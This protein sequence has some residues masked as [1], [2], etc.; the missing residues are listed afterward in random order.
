MKI[1]IEEVEFS[2]LSAVDDNGRVFF[3]D[4]RVFRAIRHDATERVL[5]LFSSGL[6]DEL[7]SN[8]LFP[9]SWVTDYTLEGY[10]LVV[11]HE[12][13]AP[14]VYP[15]EWSFSMLQDAALTVLKVNLISK[16]FGYQ[17]KDCHG[18][19]VIFDGV[20]PKFIDMGSFVKVPEDFQGWLAYEEF[21]RFFYYP[22]S[23][24]KDGNGYIAQKMLMGNMCMPHLSYLLYK[25]PLYRLLNPT[26]V[27]KF[28]ILFSALKSNLPDSMSLKSNSR[29]NYFAIR[30]AGTDIFPFKRMDFHAWT[31]K[32]EK[33]SLK[34]HA[35]MWGGYH[36]QYNKD[37]SV[38]STPRFDRVV[39]IVKE[40]K[41]TSILEL[42]GNQGVVAMLLTRE[43]PGV[44]VTCTDY[45]EY[46]VDAMYQ[47]A[48][49]R[50]ARLSS[51]L[52]DFVYPTLTSYGQNPP[53]R[54]RA[55]VVLALAVTHH[56]LLTGKMSIDS[57]FRILS[58]YT[59]RYL[60][61]E[62]MPL[63]L[64]GGTTAPP[65]PEWY[66]ADWFRENF[67]EHYELI[68]EEKLEINR[69]LFVGKRKDISAIDG[70]K[71]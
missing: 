60:L 15:Y 38:L 8:E 70:N 55:E 25:N 44:P 63:G 59:K 61:V 27:E 31:R 1:N 32:I 52:L 21:L 6:I 18:F 43:L 24:W 11:E 17:T 13:C 64:Y 30:L 48:K 58:T 40:L 7:S 42:A 4:G 65:V 53:D 19:N 62:F 29:I 10:G 20:H 45:D 49:K 57:V 16:R 12:R 54:F 35:T 36:D 5:E 51:V 26:L 69:I 41:P 33:L 67:K 3:W 9:K 46:A 47:T 37:S 68:L 28:P 22:L 56:L 39:S 66:T 50:N 71:S 34:R 23:I 2:T 14:M